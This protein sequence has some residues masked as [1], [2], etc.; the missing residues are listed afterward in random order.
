MN[1]HILAKSGYFLLSFT[2]DLAQKTKSECAEDRS[3]L[4]PTCDAYPPDSYQYKTSC[5]TIGTVH[6]NWTAA[7]DDC[8]SLGGYL[9]EITDEAEM[10]FVTAILNMSLS[11]GGM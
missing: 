5:Y 2:I 9:V 4:V 11:L 7:R 1:N 6:K 3:K 8:H 10:G